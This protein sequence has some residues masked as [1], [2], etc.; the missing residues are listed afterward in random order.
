M[1]KKY[2][3]TLTPF[4][5]SPT[6]YAGS[7]VYDQVKAIQ[8]LSDF[9]VI[10]ITPASSGK[11][12]V[13]NYQ[14]IIVHQVKMVDLPSFILP[15]LFNSINVKRILDKLIELTNKNLHDIQF[16]HGHVTYPFGIL[17]VKLAQQIGAKSIVQHHGLDVMSYTNGRFQKG[18]IRAWNKKWIDKFHV[19][20]L[21]KA[22][23]NIGVSQKTLE[24][25]KGIPGY[26][27]NKVYVLYNGV[28]TEKFYPIDGLKNKSKFTIGCVGNFWKTKDQLTLIKAVATL[29]IDFGL[30][31]LELKLIGNGEMIDSCKKYVKQHK[32]GYLVTFFETQDHTQM[33]KFYNSLDLFVLPSYDEAFGCVYT[34]A[35]ACGI[36]FIGVEG[37]GIEELV[38][39]ENKQYQLVKPKQVDELSEKIKYF[40]QN[41]DFNPNLNQS[42]ALTDLIMGFLEML[43]KNEVHSK[44]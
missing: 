13:Y 19:P 22:N 1:I 21:N 39:P 17:A 15:G 12:V 41:R 6:N 43:N 23:W 7:Y 33:N 18:F 35:Y 4:F 29:A 14:G 42:I 9:Q 26:V 8:E 30:V 5:P 16:I 38:L 27:P 40:Y 24:R 32:L 11:P 20:I 10:V 25:L 3:I 44:I 34:E 2:Y 36:P 28:N 31:N 37:Q